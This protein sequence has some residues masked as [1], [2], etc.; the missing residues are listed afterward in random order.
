ML[1]VK[2]I[3]I[4]NLYE[5][6]NVEDDCFLCD[7]L[8][9]YSSLLNIKHKYL[10]FFYKGK[11]ILK[12]DRRKMVEFKQNNIFITVIKIKN[13]IKNENRLS[14]IICPECKEYSIMNIE[15][16][17]RI[18]IEK[19]GNNHNNIFSNLTD[20]FKSQYIEDVKCQKCGNGMSNYNNTFFCDS[21]G[22]KIC[23]LCNSYKDK[24]IE[25]K[26]KFYICINHCKEYISFCKNCNKN[27]CNQCENEHLNHTLINFKRILLKNKV[28]NNLKEMKQTLDKFKN[29]I[30]N[31]NNIFFDIID[32]IEEKI[33]EYYWIND[34]YMLKLSDHLFNYDII[35]N[36]NNLNTKK[37]I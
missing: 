6:N 30:K 31:F 26:Y 23:I 29:K 12:T 16:N 7:L 37:L 15:G 2:F 22:K 27:L 28:D 1:T 20:F 19:C 11:I 13:K 10:Q 8:N 25:Y 9:K 14:H 36:I 24:F 32:K 35:N 21:S 33:K 17:N 34:Y 5:M 3:Y 18:I 4:N